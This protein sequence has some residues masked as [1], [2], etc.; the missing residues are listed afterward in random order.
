[1]VTRGYSEKIR[2]ILAGVELT[3]SDVL[4]VRRFAGRWFD[5][6]KGAISFC[7]EYLRVIIGK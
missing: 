6:C 5:S 7:S 1:M 3:T 4:V 2:L